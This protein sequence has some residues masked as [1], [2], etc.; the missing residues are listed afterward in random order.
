MNSAIYGMPYLRTYEKIKYL[1]EEMA[2]RIVQLNI[3]EEN[4]DG[5]FHK[6]SFVNSPKH[7][8]QVFFNRFK[9]KM[10]SFFTSNNPIIKDNNDLKT[11]KRR[12]STFL[13][14]PKKRKVGFNHF[15]H[16]FS[17]KSHKSNKSNNFEGKEIEDNLEEKEN[18]SFMDVN[19][20]KNDE[21][22]DNN[23]N[24]FDD[25][26]EDED[27]ND[28]DN[29]KDNDEK[30]EIKYINPK[31]NKSI[32][33]NDNS[34]F[35]DDEDDVRINNK[36]KIIKNHSDKARYFFDKEMKLLNLK[37]KNLEKKRRNQEKKNQN[38]FKPNLN[39]NSIKIVD[40]TDYIPI[41]DKAIE[42][43]HYHLS[44]IDYVQEKKRKNKEKEIQKEIEEIENHKKLHKKTFSQTNWDEFIDQE[45]FWKEE[46]KRAAEFLRDKINNEIVYQPKIDKN[47]RIICKKMNRNNKTKR[48]N[49]YDDDIFNRLYNVYKKYD[50][51]LNIKRQES[52]P[53]FRPLIN[54]PN[55]TQRT[56]KT[57]NN[58]DEHKDYSSL[59][60]KNKNIK[61]RNINS[62]FHEK[63]NTNYA[64]KYSYNI[65]SKTKYSENTFNNSALDCKITNSTTRNINMKN[66][67]KK[68]NKN[69]SLDYKN[70]K[71]NFE[72]KQ[73]NKNKSI[74]NNKENKHNYN[75]KIKEKN[76]SNNKKI[77]NKNNFK[78]KNKIKKK[79]DELNNKIT[80]KHDNKE[81]KRSKNSNKS[82]KQLKDLYD[83]I[84]MLN[85]NNKKNEKE[86]LEPE[87]MLYYLNIRDN[88]SNTLKENIILTSKKYNDFFKIQ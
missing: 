16:H 62:M 78:N 2:K 30:Y 17:I 43:H 45:N 15:A 35:D 19:R 37:N 84:K 88:T 18:I 3:G 1:A 56:L 8:S 28:N 65:N 85:I 64:A 77:I 40:K 9:T 12:Q 48:I 81:T 13:Q 31:K 33:D 42:L 22:D 70:N 87:N 80:E 47:S 82:E 50:K 21:E 61:S 41:Q 44:K 67:N 86:I 49:Y 83:E 59:I 68:I 72:K 27:E 46:K 71:S 24:D 11:K 7:K 76:I 51:K 52:M 74:I 20:I 55:K 54:K 79:E 5:K 60:K 53:T 39:Q 58:I 10:Y 38:P 57:L 75:K 6:I 36:M 25:I 69:N 26:S 34:S 23:N 32:Y 73:S 29:D 4:D 63:K 66:N 14:K